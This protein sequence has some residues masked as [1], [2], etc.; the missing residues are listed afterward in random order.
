MAVTL[1]DQYLPNEMLAACLDKAAVVVLPYRSAT[2]SGVIQLAFGREKPVITTNVGGLA[3]VV[4][5]GQ[6]G[7]VVPPE[8]PAAL[9]AAVQ[10]FFCQPHGTYSGSEYTPRKRPFFLGNAYRN[11]P[12]I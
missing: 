6:T 12:T 2:Q 5:D 1:L 10:P 7:L 3:E 4:S 11:N 9:A 8:D